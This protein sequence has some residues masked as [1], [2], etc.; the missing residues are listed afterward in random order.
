MVED[1]AF[2]HKIDCLPIFQENLNLKGHLNR[3]IGSK[4]TAILMNGGILP[5]GGVALGRVCPAQQACC[6][7]ILR[8]VMV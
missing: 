1:G 2:S 5:R 3:F 4:V 7:Y 6:S 8:T